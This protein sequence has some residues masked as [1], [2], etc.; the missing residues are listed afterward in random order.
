MVVVVIII[1]IVRIR[2]II[3]GVMSRHA[4]GAPAFTK[5][6]HSKS[7]DLRTLINSYG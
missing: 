6:R 1:I 5:H 7:P 2:I 4:C 3:I